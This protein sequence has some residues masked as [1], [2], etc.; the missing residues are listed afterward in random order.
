[1]SQRRNRPQRKGLSGRN[2]GAH[3]RGR[4]AR[5]LSLEPVF[6]EDRI[7]LTTLSQVIDAF[8][9]GMGE[10]YGG[11]SDGQG[12]ASFVTQAL[13]TT[14]KAPLLTQVSNLESLLQN[15]GIELGTVLA[16]AFQFGEPTSL[17]PD[18]DSWSTL[19]GALEQTNTGLTVLYPQAAD[20]TDIPTVGT[21]A[22]FEGDYLMV[23]W[24]PPAGLVSSSSSPLSLSIGDFGDTGLPYLDS[25]N[26]GSLQGSLSGSVGAVQAQ[27]TM[28]VDDSGPNGTPVF[29][30]MPPR[31]ASTAR[32]SRSRTSRP[33]AA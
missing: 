10:L 2:Q 11:G 7:L 16:D 19:V 4:L 25:D 12:A 8:N 29:F 13:G 17:L 31:A 22:P 33:R 21:T 30:L 32:T 27:V 20:W 1:M 6:L 15:A 14:W 9:L 24:Q 5:R 3:R 18:T 23:Q 28:G 26:S